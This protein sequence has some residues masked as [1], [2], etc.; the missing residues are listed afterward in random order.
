[1]KPPQRKEYNIKN[2]NHN[3][4]QSKSNTNGN[5]NGNGNAN[6]NTTTIMN[7]NRKSSMKKYQS[8]ATQT[9]PNLSTS[10][11]LS[12]YNSQY[13]D[14]NEYKYSNYSYYYNSLDE[15]FLQFEYED[16]EL[17]YIDQFIKEKLNITN[18]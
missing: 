7:N 15:L 2:N 6:S 14:I 18:K 1:M 4:N 5:G 3:H 17:E 8:I 11:Q 9:L 16:P 12:N 13:N 10:S